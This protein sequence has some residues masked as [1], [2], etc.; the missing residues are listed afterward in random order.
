M[1]WNSTFLYFS[2]KIKIFLSCTIIDVIH[3]GWIKLKKKFNYEYV[4]NMKEKLFLYKDVLKIAYFF[5]RMNNIIYTHWI[6]IYFFI[7]Y[8]SLFI[9]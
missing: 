8:M 7:Y 2:I 1:Y 3:L 4:L 5:N 6:I 9:S